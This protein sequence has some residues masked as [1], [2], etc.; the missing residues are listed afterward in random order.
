MIVRQATKKAKRNEIFEKL[1][2]KHQQRSQ[3]KYYHWKCLKENSLFNLFKKLDTN[4][5]LENLDAMQ[6]MSL[7]EKPRLHL[8][9]SHDGMTERILFWQHHSIDGVVLQ[10]FSIVEVNP[11][12]SKW[13]VRTVWTSMFQK[14]VKI[15]F[16]SN[17]SKTSFYVQFDK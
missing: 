12:I 15:C 4:L 9:K 14:D 7:S 1:R 11:R 3:S 10:N 6:L 17:T 13:L 8:T 16:Q 2:I 5:I